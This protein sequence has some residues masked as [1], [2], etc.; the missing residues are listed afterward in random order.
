MIVVVEQL[1]KVFTAGDLLSLD[2]QCA[3]FERVCKRLLGQCLMMVST[4]DQLH[5][6][7][8]LLC[9]AS[10]RLESRSCWHGLCCTCALQKEAYF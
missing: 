9:S 6:H 3:N 4:Y 7:V 10:T 1:L 8:A 2:N 5:A